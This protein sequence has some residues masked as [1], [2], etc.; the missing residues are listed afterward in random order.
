[1]KY[2]A[3]ARISVLKHGQ[4]YFMSCTIQNQSIAM[5]DTQDNVWMTQAEKRMMRD[6]AASR[7]ELVEY[8]KNNLDVSSDP[9]QWNIFEFY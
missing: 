7:L 6:I 4:V 2:A 9:I 5:V 8:H 3:N 1:M